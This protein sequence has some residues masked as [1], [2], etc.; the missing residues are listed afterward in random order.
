MVIFGVVPKGSIFACW[1]NVEMMSVME[2][3]GSS[4]EWAMMTSVKRI[5]WGR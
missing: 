1:T 4:A 2:D 5:I 3:R